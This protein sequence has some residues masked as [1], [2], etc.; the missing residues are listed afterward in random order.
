MS[1]I[2][3]KYEEEK[4]ACMKHK[5]LYK[6]GKALKVQNKW[7]HWRTSKPDYR[8]LLHTYLNERGHIFLNNLT[9]YSIGNW[10]NE[11]DGVS[12]V[13]SCASPGLYS[14]RVNFI[15]YFF[16]LHEFFHL[17]QEGLTSWSRSGAVARVS[18][19]TAG[20]MLPAILSEVLFPW[21][22]FLKDRTAL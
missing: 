14:L 12:D 1:K 9:H 5:E 10:S 15:Y 7:E 11:E 20:A 16:P 17:F 21:F 6:N 19:S 22:V 4:I 2:C 8:H 13:S 3:Y 18:C